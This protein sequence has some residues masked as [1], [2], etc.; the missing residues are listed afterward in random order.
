MR[1]LAIALWAGNDQEA[2]ALLNARTSLTGSAPSDASARCDIQPT[3]ATFDLGQ[4][5]LRAPQTLGNLVLGKPRPAPRR[6]QLAPGSAEWMVLPM[7][8]PQG[9]DEHGKL[10]I[11]PNRISS[12]V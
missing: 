9:V 12:P 6:N 5:G 2:P 4:V 1:R 11:I 7:P 3:L 8:V 10:M